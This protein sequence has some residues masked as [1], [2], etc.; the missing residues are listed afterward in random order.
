M[1]AS[2]YDLKSFY[3]TR[4]GRVMRRVLRQRLSEVWPDCKGLRVLGTGYA[5]PY[6]HRITKDAERSIAFMAAGGG[7]HH[8][9]HDEKNKVM[10]AQMHHLP[11][12]TNSIDR[13][14]MVHDIEHNTD[15]NLYLSEIWRVL[16]SNGRLLVVAPNRSGIWARNDKTPFGQGHPYS[17][18]QLCRLLDDNKF[19]HERT[20]EALFMPP[21]SYP[22]I[23]KLAPLFEGIGQSILPFVAGVHIVEVSKQLYAKAD[24][25]TGSK[26]SA[27]VNTGLMPKPAVTRANSLLKKE[28]CRRDQS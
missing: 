13:V 9:P 24:K 2:V 3:N 20:E 7:V 27:R 15:V 4:L 1:V 17:V 28:E 16:K 11:I 10:Y 21:I 26:V 23:L 22:P 18:R 8:W 14:L 25:G 5:V 12:E 6:L 19:V